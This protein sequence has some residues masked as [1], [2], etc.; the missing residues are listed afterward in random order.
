MLLHNRFLCHIRIFT[1][2]LKSYLFSFYE[3]EQNR[4]QSENKKAS[5]RITEQNCKKLYQLQRHLKSLWKL[6]TLTIN[7]EY[8]ALLIRFLRILSDNTQHLNSFENLELTLSYKRSL[9]SELLEEAQYYKIWEYMSHISINSITLLEHCLGFAHKFHNLRRLDLFCLFSSEQNYSLFQNLAL[10]PNLQKID[11][12]MYGHNSPPTLARFLSYFRLPPSIEKLSFRVNN[13]IPGIVADYDEDAIDEILDSP[14][15]LE[16]LEAWEGLG[17][18]RE[19]DIGIGL[20]FRASDVH[21]LGAFFRK[22]SALKELNLE[23]TNDFGGINMERLYQAQEPFY[24]T[25]FL[26]KLA[27]NDLSLE[28]LSLGASFVAIGEIT[29]GINNI[30]SRLKSLTLTGAVRADEN[31]HEFMHILPRELDQLGMDQMIVEDDLGLEHLWKGLG[32]VTARELKLTMHMEDLVKEEKIVEKIGKM[33]KHFKRSEEF[34]VFVNNYIMGAKSF[35]EIKEMVVKNGEKLAHL[36]GQVSDFNCN[37]YWSC[38]DRKI[39]YSH[40][41]MI[42]EALY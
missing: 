30:L 7:G 39:Y 2:V 35:L 5:V 1:D 40:F 16:L 4:N 17:K 12:L 10:V 11:I 36:K 14:S 9:P 33:I 23:L 31:F 19:I 15:V 21:V 22:F 8:D 13:S 18:L 27:D 32:E 25:D 26:T 41:D 20:L 3:F 42:C 24:L 37:V 38:K 34:V 29:K 6:K 28:R